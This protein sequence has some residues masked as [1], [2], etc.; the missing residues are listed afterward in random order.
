MAIL[1]PRW[2]DFSWQVRLQMCLKFCT[3]NIAICMGSPNEQ[4]H[5]FCRDRGGKLSRRDTCSKPRWSWCEATIWATNCTTN[6]TNRQIR[7]TPWCGAENRNGEKLEGDC[8]KSTL[9]HIRTVVCLHDPSRHR[10]SA[11]RS[12][13]IYLCRNSLELSRG[14]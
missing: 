7:Q 1:V 6:C 12:L 4:Y 10:L 5:N 11:A 8:H 9:S 2:L 3:V 13:T 14:V